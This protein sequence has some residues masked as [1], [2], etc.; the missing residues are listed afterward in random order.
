MSLGMCLLLCF[1]SYRL[2]IYNVAHPGRLWGYMLLAW[3]HLK[4]RANG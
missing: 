1:L 3:Q 4:E 2:A